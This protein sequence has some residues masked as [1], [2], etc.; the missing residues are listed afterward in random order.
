M[1]GEDIGVFKEARLIAH[2][3]AADIKFRTLPEFQERDRKLRKIFLP[4]DDFEGTLEYGY[5]ARQSRQF[6]IQESH[7]TTCLTGL[8]SCVEEDIVK[9]IRDTMEIYLSFLYCSA[10]G[11]L[12]QGLYY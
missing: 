4:S 3:L 1:Q 10:S 11:N 9:Y 5:N 2:S 8:N 6:D 7:R 12:V